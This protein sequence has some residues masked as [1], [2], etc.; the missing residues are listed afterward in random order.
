MEKLKSLKATVIKY[1]MLLPVFSILVAMF[2]ITHS[3]SVL[4]EGSTKGK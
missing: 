1:S 3:Q 2:V 4:A